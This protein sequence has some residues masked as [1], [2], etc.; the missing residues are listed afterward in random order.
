[1]QTMFTRQL[2]RMRQG[3]VH[4]TLLAGLLFT[5]HA[6]ASEADQAF[7][8]LYKEEWQKRQLQYAVDENAD[9]SRIPVKLPTVHAQAQAEHA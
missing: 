5:H 3:F 4:L 7:E 1:M 9:V 6:L 2:G 8:S